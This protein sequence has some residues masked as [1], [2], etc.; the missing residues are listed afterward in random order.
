MSNILFVDDDP[1]YQGVIRD[2]LVHEGYAVDCASD[3]ADGLRL[4]RERVYDLV[5]SD[6]KMSSIDGHQFL[7]LLRKYDDDIKVIILT[8]SDDEQDEIKSLDLYASEFLKKSAPIAVILKRIEHVL[9]E[10]TEQR[11][12]VL[13][14]KYEDIEVN[15]KN[16]RVTKDGA[17]VDLTAREYTLLT[18]F[19]QYKNV[20]HSRE[21]ILKKV[22]RSGEAY[23]DL[24]IVDAYVKKLRQKMNLSCISSVRSVGYEWVE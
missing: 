9:R 16:R 1:K 5:I 10:K 23:G 2:L 12:L 21:E 20:T 6:L 17:E 11:Q 24:R 7:A 8:G 19:L 3:A 18:F 4:F 13:S 22:W 15:I 14:S